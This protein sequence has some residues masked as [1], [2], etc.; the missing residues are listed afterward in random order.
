MGRKGH[1][2]LVSTIV[3]HVKDTKGGGKWVGNL[4]SVV[5]EELT[6]C[7]IRSREDGD[8]VGKQAEVI[9]VDLAEWAWV[10]GGEGS[11]GETID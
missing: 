10:K 9:S 1:I 7:T 2:L 5:M 3:T 8:G 4:Y 11:K 6:I